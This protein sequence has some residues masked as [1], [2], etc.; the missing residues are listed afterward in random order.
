MATPRVR[1]I[2]R[3]GGLGLTGPDAQGFH[4]KIGCS[5]KG[6]VYELLTAGNADVLRDAIGDGPLMEAAAH[7]LAVAGGPMAVMTVP[8]ATAG[9]PGSVTKA[10][11]GTGTLTPAARPFVAAIIKAVSTGALGTA[12]VRV[13]LDGGASWSEEF[14]SPLTATAWPIPVAPGIQV[15]FTTGGGTDLTIG[16]TFTLS[17]STMV[18]SKAGT[19]TATAAVTSASVLDAYNIRVQLLVGATGIADGAAQFRYTL[20]GGDTWS[21]VISVPVSGTYVIPG[22]GL[23]ITFADG[24]GTSWVAGDTFAFTCTGPSYTTTELNAAMDALAA[25][26]DQFEFVHVVGPAADGSGAAAVAAALDVKL[27]AMRNQYRYVWGIIE[28]PGTETDS[29][30]KSAFL[31]TSTTRVI[32][33]AGDVELT[34]SVTSRSDRRNAAW[35]FAAR[36]AAI[37][38]AEDAGRVASGGCPGVTRLYRDE[39]ATPGLDDAR[40]TTMTTIVG[41]SGFF[42]TQGKML[43]PIGSDFELV[44]HRRVMDK[45]MRIGRTVLVQYLNDKVRVDKTTGRILEKEALQ[46]EKRVEGVLAGAMRPGA[47]V[48]DCSALSVYV[49]R[50]ENILSTKRL[51]VKI[52]LVPFGYAKD[53]EADVGFMNPKLQLV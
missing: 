32:G 1:M 12:R 19:G 46:I 53:I 40:I 47:D 37:P 44:Q 2:E 48:G 3:D 23:I 27:L 41:I 26:S 5:A 29:N 36:V 24:A 14:T 38:P 4:V 16:D 15:T 10:G 30:I 51:P 18:V 13:S 33:V 45:A 11:L 25:L 42:V 7:A 43:A 52:R 8:P 35:V 21:G 20:D 49:N 34:S 31:S 17:L 50:D 6:K 39:R 22:V 9:A 28:I